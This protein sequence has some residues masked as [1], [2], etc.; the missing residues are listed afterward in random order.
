MSNASVRIPTPLRPLAGD[1]D[2]VSVRGTTVGEAIRTLD[3]ALAER[4]L[5]PAGEVRQFVNVY[6]GKGHPCASAARDAAWR[7][8]CARYRTCR[9]RRQREKGKQ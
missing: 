9:G 1:A 3:P 2:D 8:R 6:L 4:L 7:R 5:T